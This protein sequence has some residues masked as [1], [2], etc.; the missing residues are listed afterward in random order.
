[1]TANTRPS[2]ISRARTPIWLPPQ[3]ET[4]LVETLRKMPHRPV[5][6]QVPDGMNHDGGENSLRQVVEP[7]RQ[8]QQGQRNSGRGGDRR[9][10]RLRAIAS[11][12]AVPEVPPPTCMPWKMAEVALASPGAQFLIGID[13]VS[14]LAGEGASCAH[15]LGKQHQHKA[16]RSWRGLQPVG[17]SEHGKPRQRQ[18]GRDCADDVHAV[19]VQFKK[20]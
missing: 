1:M 4:R 9:N 17:P 10:L 20:P 12:A 13:L 8:E 11:L 16:N 2:S 15:R 7:A 3:S 6:Q 5:V 14:V 18:T 19:A